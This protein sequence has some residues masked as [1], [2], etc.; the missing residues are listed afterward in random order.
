MDGCIN[1]V[2]LDEDSSGRA[3]PGR[4]EWS[5][6]GF[7]S[8]F[9]WYVAVLSARWHTTPF[10]DLYALI[11]KRETAQ[12]IYPPIRKREAV[13]LKASKSN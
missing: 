7:I 4:V 8:H 6:G 10:T 9:G 11:G 2:V 12:L 5:E 13:K 3:G 1:I